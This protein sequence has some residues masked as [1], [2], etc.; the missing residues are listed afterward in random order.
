MKRLLPIIITLIAFTCI[1]K[2][3]YGQITLGSAAARFA[4]FT[5]AGAVSDN[6]SAHSLVTGDVGTSTVGPI[7]GFGNVNGVMHPGADLATA[8]CATA[9]NA[10]IAQLNLAPATLFPSASMGSGVT[11]TPGVYSIPGNATLTLNLFLDAQSDPNAQFII[12]IGG[13]FGAN[14]NSKV[15]LIGGAKACNVYWQITGAASMAALSTMRGNIISGGAINFGSGDSLEGRAFSTVGLIAING[16]TIFTPTGCGSPILNGPTL[17]NMGSIICYTIFSSN[18]ALANSVGTT[19]VTGDVGNNGGGSITGWAPAAV[20]G[21]LHTVPDSSTIKAAVDLSKLHDSLNAMPVDIELLFPSQFGKNLTLTPHVYLMNSGGANGPAVLTDSLYLDAQNNPNGVFVI[22]I[23]AGAFSTGTFAKVKLIN[24]AQAKNVFWLVQGAVSINNFSVMKG[25]IV[26]PTGA[27]NLVNTGIILDGRVLSMNGAITTA[28]LVAT[29]PPG[30][31]ALAIDSQPTNQ[32]VCSGDTAKFSIKTSLPGL[33]FRWRKGLINLTDNAH[34]SGSGTTV[35]KIFPATIA[36]TSTNYNVQVFGTD[37]TTS[38]VVSLTVNL[39][40]VI[41]QEPINKKMCTGDSVYFLVKATGSNLT[42][43][44]RKGLINIKDTLNYSGATTDS[45]K[46]KLVS[47]S[48]TASN[49][50]VVV[51]GICSPKDSSIN[52]SLLLTSAPVISIEPI[53]KNVCVGNLA[54]FTVSSNDTGLTYRWRK[55]GIN[56]INGINIT[57]VNTDTL[58][59]LSVTVLDTSSFYDVI[60]TGACSLRDTSVSTKL[61]IGQSPFITIQ[62]IDTSACLGNGVRFI[63]VAIGDSLTYQW[64]KGNIN[65]LDTGSISGSTNDTL[66]INPIRLSDT[67]SYYNV[68]IQGSCAT[69]IVSDSVVL[70]VNQAPIITEEPVNI[71]KCEGD[72]A[73][74]VVKATGSNLSYQW[75]KGTSNVTNSSNISG[76]NS[77]TLKI[78]AITIAD[79]STQYYVVVS[80]SCAPADSSVY[81]S[82]NVNKI[83]VINTEP[84]NQIACEGSS[85]SVNAIANGSN[86]TYQWRRGT[87]NLIDTGSISGSNSNQLTINPAQL[88]DADTSYYL[89]IT[90]TCGAPIQTIRVSITVNEVP[91]ALASGDTLLCIND[92]LR[93]VAQTIVGATYQWT[94]P[95]SFSSTDQNPTILNAAIINSGLYTLVV[96]RNSCPSLPATINININDC[97]VNIRIIKTASNIRPIINQHVDFTINVTNTG[98]ANAS[99]VSVTDILKSGY[100]YVSSTTTV[101]TYNPTTGIWLIGDLAIGQTATATIKALVKATGDYNNTATVSGNEIDIDIADNTASITLEPT[102]FFIPEGFSPNGDGINDLFIIR[103]IEYYPSCSI[104]IYN[105]WGSLVYNAN[106][107]K[108]D[109]DGKANN[110]ISIGNESLPIGSYF[111]LI[112]LGDETD[113]IKGT[114]YLNK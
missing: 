53:N 83:A 79:S 40:P 108:N 8:A 6:A 35:L 13:T 97:S 99:G 102:D 104:K 14:T 23:I 2:I 114:I 90:G 73:L 27:I 92:T 111:Y 80:G 54:V 59:I 64:R 94:G 98:T 10:T 62:P 57:G 9:L 89:I 68:Q 32:T 71:S 42:Y 33:T 45:L 86:L 84:T 38:N 34:I 11:F 29:M 26:V 31:G 103:G 109:W 43:Q 81:V 76:A 66:L 87:N 112:D 4:I 24:G 36:D 20:T 18:G 1:P 47:V 5:N 106:P 51:S 46:I 72:T 67:S 105:R 49:Y 88:S 41:S 25:T 7:T 28:G 70:I 100:T 95:N 61:L 107:Y 110:G 60:I 30:C 74:F 85:I 58:R 82:L 48:D 16:M 63:V 56:L 39:P 12:K 3:N 91:I 44:W 65:L 101:G 55:N 19:V 69:S 78:N 96:T 52:V 15:I 50:N 93:L 17:P 22:K 113:V 37:T 75:K 77:D 21:T